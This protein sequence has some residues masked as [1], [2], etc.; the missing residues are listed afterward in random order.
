MNN[1]NRDIKFRGKDL[2]T[3]E[4]KYGYAVFGKENQLA[5]IL[6]EGYEATYGSNPDQNIFRV[7]PD[8][9]NQYTGLK[10]KAGRDIYEGDI[11][12]IRNPNDK[13]ITKEGVE[14]HGDFWNTTGYVFWWNEEGGWYHGHV[15]VKNGNGRPPKRMWEYV[16]VIGNEYETPE[17][18]Q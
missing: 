8:T 11:V 15:S 7:N 5:W 13:L 2:L 9:V 12:R 10:D 16:E 14:L 3:G 1:M 4:W 18:L 6:T 17:L